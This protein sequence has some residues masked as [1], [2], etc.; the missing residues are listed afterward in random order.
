MV[1]FR[2]V[3]EAI[4]NTSSGR[5]GVDPEA[6]PSPSL[7]L[8]VI[9]KGE[10]LN[11]E[12]ELSEES[13]AGTGRLLHWAG[14][15]LQ[16][17]HRPVVELGYRPT[18]EDGRPIDVFISRWYHGSPAHRYGVYALNWVAS[19]NGIPTPDL[20]EFVRVTQG[21]EDCAF[22]RL[23][24]IS[25]TGRPKVLTVKLDLHYWPTWEL[26]RTTDG[27]NEWERVLL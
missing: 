26:R 16:P 22:V 12:A 8:T 6:T 14:C 7:P 11:V 5:V 20:D 24:L 25:L 10:L 9:R 3:E 19:V 27:T 2:S 17:T 21:L 13:C 1:S 4:A 15:Q 23:K 18:T